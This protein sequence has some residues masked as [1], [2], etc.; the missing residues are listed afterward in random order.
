VFPTVYPSVF[1]TSTA[2]RSV[3]SGRSTDTYHVPPCKSQ[4]LTSTER[5]TSFVPPAMCLGFR[6]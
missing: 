1:P 4:G 2:A 6:V 5:T 3:F